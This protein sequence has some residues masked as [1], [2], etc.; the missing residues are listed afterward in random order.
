MRNNLNLSYL[1]KC[2]TSVQTIHKVISIYHQ[3]GVQSIHPF[4]QIFAHCV[5]VL[6]ARFEWPIGSCF[7]QYWSHCYA[8]YFVFI[9]CV[10]KT[11]LYQCNKSFSLCLLLSLTFIITSYFSF[12]SFTSICFV[13]FNR[14]FL[15]SLILKVQISINHISVL[16]IQFIDLFDRSTETEDVLNVYFSILCSV[17]WCKIWK[18]KRKR[19]SLLINIQINSC[20]YG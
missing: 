1:A 18:Y 6:F 9:L 12:I 11:L 7:Q 5:Q 8:G 20:L 17:P 16:P 4:S 3:F 13:N 14:K 19:I 10:L 15:K 2:D